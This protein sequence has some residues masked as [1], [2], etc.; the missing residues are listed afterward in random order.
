MLI[1]EGTPPVL[2]ASH[3]SFSAERCLQPDTMVTKMT[4]ELQ[5]CD[6]ATSGGLL[7]RQ[8]RAMLILLDVRVLSLGLPY[9]LIDVKHRPTSQIMVPA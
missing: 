4:R 3:L 9:L 6:S 7:I 2:S 5:S 1:D 8:M